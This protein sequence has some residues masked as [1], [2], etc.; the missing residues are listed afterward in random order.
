MLLRLLAGQS[1][2]RVVAGRTRGNAS[3]IEETQHPVGRLGALAKPTLGHLDPRFLEIMDEVRTMLRAA[4]A[5]D[6]INYLMLMM[7]DP[8]VHFHV[9]PRYAEDRSFA[10]AAFADAGWPAAPDLKAVNETS[11]EQ[12]ARVIAE[13]RKHW[14]GSAGA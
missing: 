13:L 11:A 9:L 1:L 12:R 7:V 5:Y 8:H 3:G 4:F 6:K 2:F 14:P 10:G